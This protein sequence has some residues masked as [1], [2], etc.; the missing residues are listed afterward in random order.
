MSHDLLRV[1]PFSD[2]TAA[3]PR[4]EI[5]AFFPHDRVVTAVNTTYI[6][7]LY[8]RPLSVNFSVKRATAHSKARNVIC[9]MFV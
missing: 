1:K 5:M 6:N 9:R 7:Y 8:I 4:R 2:T 3:P